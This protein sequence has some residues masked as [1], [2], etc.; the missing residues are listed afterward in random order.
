M[1]R[2]VLI[3]EEGKLRFGGVNTKVYK[4]GV[5]FILYKIFKEGYPIEEIY[6]DFNMMKKLICI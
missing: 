3:E 6:S 4:G 2:L 5:S 1:G